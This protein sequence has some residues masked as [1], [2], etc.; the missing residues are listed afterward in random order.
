MKGGIIR[1]GSGVAL[2]PSTTLGEFL[3]SFPD[4]SLRRVS[5]DS[6]IYGLGA[7]EVSGRSFGI[8]AKFTGQA[9]TTVRLM[10]TVGFEEEE[11]RRGKME[12]DQWLQGQGLPPRH[13]GEWGHYTSGI[14]EK[15]AIADVIFVYL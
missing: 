8:T 15:S 12:N 7:Q 3:T 2:G 1:L 11:L 13:E 6:R 14:D 4:A 5:G 10:A 9:L